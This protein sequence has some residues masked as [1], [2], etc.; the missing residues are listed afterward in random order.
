MKEARGF[1][2]LGLLII[3]GTLAVSCAPFGRGAETEPD[4]TG[5]VTEVHGDGTE[6]IEGLVLVEAEVVTT[7]GEYVDKYMLTV[8]DKTS[9]L[10]GDGGNG[11]EVTFEA[12][13]VGQEVQVWFAGPVKESYPMQVDAR[14]I[15]IVG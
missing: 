6:G 14:Q 8:T 11:R 7:E 15:V 10:Q 1:R 9:I 4:F 12:L 3:L 2:W 13:A 5:R